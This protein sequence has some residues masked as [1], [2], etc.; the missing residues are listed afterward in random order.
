MAVQDTRKFL[1]TGWQF[2]VR[3]SA[4]GGFSYS[5]DEQSIQEAIWILLGT[6]RGE[7]QMLPRFG[8]GIH[9]MVFAPNNP[10]TQGNVK[11]LVKDALNEWEPRIDVLD[12]DV[13]SPEGSPT[14]LLIRVDYRIRSNNTFGNLVYPFYINEDSGS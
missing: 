8:C 12:V 13:S 1:G 7:R 3:I 11:F 6:A 4:S 5:S 14:T 10:A 9:D 2:P